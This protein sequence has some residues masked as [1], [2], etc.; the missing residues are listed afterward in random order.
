MA[1]ID[2]IKLVTGDTLPDLRMVI[3]DSN[4]AAAGYTLDP[5]DPDT[6][7][8]MDLTNGS[9]RLLIRLVGESTVSKVITGILG[10][11]ANGA[12]IFSFNNN[13][14]DEEGVY[15][16]EVEITFQDG[17]VQT[18]HDLIKFKVRSDFD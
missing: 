18:I 15:E 10:D 4:A 13:A 14:F 6:W 5:N 9:G 7:A 1:Y 12:I 2:T 11:A 3:K 17:G 16:G 8:T